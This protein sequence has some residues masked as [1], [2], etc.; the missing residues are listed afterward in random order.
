MAEYHD[1][2]YSAWGCR[3]AKGCRFPLAWGCRYESRY[4]D[5]ASLRLGGM[6]L[7]VHSW[8]SP[9]PSEPGPCPIRVRPLYVSEASPKLTATATRPM[10][11]PTSFSPFSP[12][13]PLVPP[14]HILSDTCALNISQIRHGQHLGIYPRPNFDH[15]PTALITRTARRASVAA[16]CCTE[17]RLGG[18]A[19]LQSRPFSNKQAYSLSTPLLSLRSGPPVAALLYG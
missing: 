5:A 8:S 9:P 10:P 13:S 18:G 12:F 4:G 16:P 19:A 11:Q 6:P 2:W 3:F 1:S 7:R 15:L 17:T 14:L